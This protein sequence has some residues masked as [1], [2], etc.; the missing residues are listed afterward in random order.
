MVE[1]EF[2]VTEISNLPKDKMGK[3]EYEENCGE[4]DKTKSYFFN[5]TDPDRFYI[6]YKLS[7]DLANEWSY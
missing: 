5:N 1:N 4:K 3:Y 6:K 7:T 2:F